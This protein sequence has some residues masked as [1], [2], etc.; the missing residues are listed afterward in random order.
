MSLFLPLSLSLKHTHIQQET[1]VCVKTVG[2][3]MGEGGISESDRAQIQSH[4]ST[5]ITHK[6]ARTHTHRLH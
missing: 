6:H 2:R 3:D 5:P 1:A 4:F